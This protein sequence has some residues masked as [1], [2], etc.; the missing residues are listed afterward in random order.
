M[1]PTSKPQTLQTVEKAL[2][3]MEFV[4]GA[5]EP[6]TVQQVAAGLELNITSAY[7]LMRTLVA[8]RYV[9]RRDDATLVLGA[10][11]GNLFRAYRKTF[12]IHQ[13]LSALVDRLAEETSETCFLSVLQDHRVVLKVLVEGTQNLRVSGLYVGLSG[14][15]QNRASGKAVMAFV[16]QSERDAILASALGDMPARAR[17]AAIA[18]LERQLAA[19]RERGWSLDEAQTQ[20]GIASIGAPVFDAKGKIYGAI[21]VVSPTLRMDRSQDDFVRA[22][23][24]A[25]EEASALLRL[26]SDI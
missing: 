7:H 23:R 5:S 3:F 15:E 21:G 6:P 19:T 12:S 1:R 25:A 9:E 13:S 2:T 8:R 14:N 17:K 4:A 20:Q 16:E 22:A 11:V 10:E 26:A 18:T 24:A